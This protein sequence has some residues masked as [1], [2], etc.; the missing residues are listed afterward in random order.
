[1]SVTPITF[2]AGW[3]GEVV[4]GG[5]EGARADASGRALPTV[6]QWQTLLG[7]LADDPASLSGY[8]LL[9]YSPRGEVFRARLVWDRRSLEVVC[10]RSRVLS[11]WRR[12]GGPL[13]P[14]REQR[15]FARGQ[16]LLQAGIETALPLARIERRRPQRR[17]CLVTEFVPDL[18]DLN[19]VVLACLP[20]LDARQ[21]RAVKD[22]IIDRVVDLVSRLERSGLYHRDLK[23]SNILLRRWDGS[24]G[25]VG[26]LLVDLDGIRRGGPAGLSRRWQ[27]LVRLAASLTGSA[28]ATRSDHCRFLRAYLGG[29][30]LPLG[31]WKQRFRKLRRRVDRYVRRA[32]GRKMGKLDGYTGDRD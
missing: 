24:G 7:P 30:G 3:S 11:F 13:S 2:G 15:N 25:P 21:G 8:T 6:E 22:A 29:M 9:K 18:I 14:S 31:M 17:A 19:Q 27:P 4:A 23:A 26:V 1:M 32:R 16:A 5:T 28:A 12:L 20:K 10:R